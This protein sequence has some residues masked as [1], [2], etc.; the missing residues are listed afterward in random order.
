M[1]RQIRYLYD[2][3][4]KKLS[5]RSVQKALKQ[6]QRKEP[7]MASIHDPQ[8]KTVCVCVSCSVLASV[9]TLAR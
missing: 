6:M 7:S 4:M 9:H 5:T 3:E 2:I 8:V 1:L